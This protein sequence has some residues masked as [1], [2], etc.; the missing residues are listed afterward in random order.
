M[1]INAILAAAVLVSAASW[2]NAALPAIAAEPS[3]AEASIT[4]ASAD[5]AAFSQVGLASFYVPQGRTAS[6]AKSRPHALTA[7]HRRLPFGS[8]VRIT[9]LKSGKQVVV[10][11]TDRGPFSKS[12]IIDISRAAAKALGMTQQGVARVRITLLE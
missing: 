12:R 8:R 3:G 11:I 2:L 9:H 1:K 7:A 6:G 10:T 4:K 5:K